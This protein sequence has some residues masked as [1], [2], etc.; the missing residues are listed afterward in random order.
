MH[1]DNVDL[2]G[3]LAEFESARD[4]AVRVTEAYR[5]CPPF[6]PGRERLFHEVVTA[7]EAAEQH[8]RRWLE[9]A[10]V[11]APTPN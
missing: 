11:S 10:R 8:L 4:T 3:V 7:T 1:T 9:L 6:D 5:R 2:A